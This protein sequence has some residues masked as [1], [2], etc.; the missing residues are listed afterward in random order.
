[1]RPPETRALWRAVA[2]LALVSLGRWVWSERGAAPL[3]AGESV[4]PELLAT[5]RAAAE[6]GAR[7]RSPLG[8]TERLDP[9]RASEVELDRLPGVGPAT[10]RAIVAARESGTVFRS[11]EDLLSVRGIGPSTLAKM[12]PA[13]DLGGPPA[14]PPRPPGAR[15]GPLPALVDV[16][17]ATGPDL[18]ALPGIGPALAERIVEARKE[19]MFT[20]LDD[21]IR[22]RGIGAATVERLRP[23][24]T[25]GPLR[26]GRP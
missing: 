24:A 23:Y 10:A 25:V 6:E 19:Q 21:L 18:Q 3:P 22:V 1:M 7:R 26:R 14:A 2:L 17:R 16:N 20:S 12:R 5:T 15:A 13:L 8:A 11:P 9:N 4:L